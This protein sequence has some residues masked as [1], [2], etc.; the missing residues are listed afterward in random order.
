MSIVILVLLNLICEFLKAFYWKNWIAIQKMSLRFRVLGAKNLDLI[1]IFYLDRNL[2]LTVWL[3]CSYSIVKSSWIKVND[4]V[5]N[6]PSFVRSWISFSLFRISNFFV[7]FFSFA[8][9]RFS[10]IILIVILKHFPKSY[11]SL[12]NSPHLEFV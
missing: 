3:L 7:F 10:A 4:K 1:I 12:I 2:N 5:F 6:Q 9:H 11:L 8:L